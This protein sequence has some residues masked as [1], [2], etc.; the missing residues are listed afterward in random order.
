MYCQIEKKKLLFDKMQHMDA[1]AERAEAPLRQAGH[2]FR[3]E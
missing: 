2:F 3:P 1:V